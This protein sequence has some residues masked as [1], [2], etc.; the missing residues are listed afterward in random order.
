[1]KRFS[2]IKQ[3]LTAQPVEL[4]DA[5]LNDQEICFI[6]LINSLVRS[7]YVSQLNHKSSQDDRLHFKKYLLT[8]YTKLKKEHLIVIMFDI[9][10][11]LIKE[12]LLGIGSV[13]KVYVYERNLFTELLSNN[14]RSCILAHNHPS[15]IPEPS[16]EDRVTTSFLQKE[17]ANIQIQLLD[18]YIV[19]EN[20]IYS[21]LKS[22]YL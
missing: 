16:V 3:L 21:I 22:V 20:H 10:G 14:A 15:G 12:S 4:K 7:Y 13:N 1:M 8:H 19:G 2:D 17:L 6:K 11:K 9:N 18:H 5:G